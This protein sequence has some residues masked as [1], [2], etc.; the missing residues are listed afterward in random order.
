MPGD[1]SGMPGDLRERNQERMPITVSPVSAKL[2][3]GRR[4]YRDRIERTPRAQLCRA[5]G[6]YGD[7]RM[8]REARR[9]VHRVHKQL[10]VSWSGL[11]VDPPDR[12]AATAVTPRKTVP[13]NPG[14]DFGVCHGGH[15]LQTRNSP[16]TPRR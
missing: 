10:E 8:T 12:A 11:L 1:S 7:Y 9:R 16:L 3:C 13:I 5:R 4:Y 6:H 14:T 2:A 15:C